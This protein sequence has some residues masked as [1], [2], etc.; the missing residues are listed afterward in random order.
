MMHLKERYQQLVE[1]LLFYQDIWKNEIMLLYPRPLDIYPAEWVEDLFRF[2]D[3][4]S[5]WQL[6]HYQTLGQL[7]SPS[8]KHYF[9]TIQ[10]LSRIPQSSLAPYSPPLNAWEYMTPKKQHEIAHIFPLIQRLKE[11]SGVTKIVDIGGGQGHFAQLLSH[12][13][14]LEVQ[15]LDMD[16][17]VQ[18]A[19]AHRQ[20]KKWGD[21]P[22]AV[23]FIPHKLGFP[24]PAFVEKLHARTLTMGLHTCGSL[25]CAQLMNSSEK[26][27]YI[28]NIGCCY[29]KLTPEF[30]HLSAEARKTPLPWNQ[31]ALT[32]ASGPY[33]K[34]SKHDVHLRNQVKRFRYAF[35]MLLH[36]H[37]G[38]SDQVT[39]GNSREQLYFGE[40]ATYAREQLSR[41]QLSFHGSDSEL[42][43]FQSE[44]KRLH[45]V[46]QMISTGL[47]RDALS[48]PLELAI[49]IDRALWLEERGYEVEVLEVFDPHLSP[50][51]I[52]LIA[53]L[54]R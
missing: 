35:H 50:R 12:H 4:A 25:A 19:G 39:L 51:N 9:Q 13:L 20:H 45:L 15:S 1:F 37:F 5:L 47:V 22:F 27:A 23:T 34:V 10:E 43:A 38:I 40:F 48:R 54:R 44:P 46:N 49:L 2:L 33:K 29:H 21:S 8:L 30:F 14:Q 31:Y 42:N 41:L 24:D 52:A 18:R 16:A 36:D 6:T 3:S 53:Q 7:H 11:Q 26:E 32:L 28:F 17:K